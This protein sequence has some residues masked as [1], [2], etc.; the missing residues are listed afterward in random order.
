MQEWIQTVKLYFY[1]LNLREINETI[2]RTYENKRLFRQY[3]RRKKITKILRTIS[4]KNIKKQINI[5]IGLYK[6]NKL[7]KLP[8]SYIYEIFRSAEF[9]K[10]GMALTHSDQK[11]L[12]RFLECSNLFYK[13]GPLKQFIEHIERIISKS[14]SNENKARIINVSEL[15]NPSSIQDDDL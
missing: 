3:K 14:L 11:I 12:D 6:W 15:H 10:I 2:E 1:L 5:I 4:L 7:K 13:E 9:Y 8:D